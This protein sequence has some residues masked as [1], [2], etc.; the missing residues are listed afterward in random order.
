VSAHSSFSPATAIFDPQVGEIVGVERE[1]GTKI[2]MIVGS[3][4]FV[5]D[6]Q[7]IHMALG[8]IRLVAAKAS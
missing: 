2:D 3:G 4:F 6:S 1:T 7:V 8:M 5:G